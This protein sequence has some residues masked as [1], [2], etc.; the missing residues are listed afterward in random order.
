[1]NL[2]IS[3]QL[4]LRAL[5]EEY[6][7]LIGWP[8]SLL[9]VRREVRGGM[10]QDVFELMFS[11][12]FP[13]FNAL[14]FM[15]E[16]EGSYRIFCPNGVPFR[17]VVLLRWYEMMGAAIQLVNQLN[18]E[19]VPGVAMLGFSVWTPPEEGEEDDS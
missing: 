13:S 3:E 11:L 12:S 2:K 10:E 5:G 15:Q 9:N 6:A 19:A 7:E 16:D 4:R 18:A 14:V 1:M 8:K 17:Y